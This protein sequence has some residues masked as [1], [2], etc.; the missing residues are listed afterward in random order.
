LMEAGFAHGLA[1]YPIILSVNG[2]ITVVAEYEDDKKLCVWE[3][4]RDGS[5]VSRW[6]EIGGIDNEL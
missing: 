3:F 2:K 4:G 5:A 1:G 6:Y